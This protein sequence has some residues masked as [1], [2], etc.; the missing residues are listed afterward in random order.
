MPADPRPQPLVARYTP[1]LLPRLHASL[2]MDEPLAK[3]VA[4]TGGTVLPPDEL[5]AF[6]D[7]E[8]MFANANDPAE[9]SHIENLL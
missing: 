2:V 6:G 5:R 1:A 7:L 9:L 4:E 8:V 3:F